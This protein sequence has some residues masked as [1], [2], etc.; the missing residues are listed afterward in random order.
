MSAVSSAVAG[1]SDAPLRIVFCAKESQSR[2]WLDALRSAFAGQGLAVDL[3]W[4]DA[5]CTE[6]DADAQQ[7]EAALVWRPPAA[8]FA[9]Q[10][11]LK[12]VF[13]LGAGVDALLAMPAFPR[14][15]MLLRLEDAGM[16]EALAEYVL[17]AVLRVYRGF[18]RYAIQQ[19]AA[20]WQPLP[21]RQRA[22]F[23]VG[24]LG[25]GVI[26]SA[27]AGA[28]A[29]HGFAVRGLAR[30][31]RAIEGVQSFAG[32]VDPRD[33]AC[34]AFL[35]Q[36]DVLVAVLPLTDVTRGALN[37]ALFAPL[38]P[39][40]HLVNVGRGAQLNETDL[41]AALDGGQ[42]GG[43]TLDVFAEEPLPQAHPF[44]ARPE[45]L[46]TPH[47]SAVTQLGPSVRQVAEKLA[48]WARGAAVDGVV[49]PLRGY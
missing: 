15:A 13:N 25:L 46:V 5:A 38:A 48:A 37:A 3:W 28:L 9:E 12:L 33:V 40:A 1:R 26:G 10:R 18:D 4:R 14:T 11:A 42:L 36:L 24:V 47:V 41:L 2:V 20:R 23:R 7:A 8:L 35:D 49:D 39:G 29:Q 19:R 43:A 21:L 22:D 30:S 6:V 32:A 45:I 27:I 16:S 44:W 31:P 34:R 17:A